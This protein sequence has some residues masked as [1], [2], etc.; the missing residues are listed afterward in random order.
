VNFPKN[1]VQ[2]KQGPKEKLHHDNED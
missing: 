2:K 1:E